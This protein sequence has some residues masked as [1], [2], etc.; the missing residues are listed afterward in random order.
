MT[1]RPADCTCDEPLTEQSFMCPTCEQRWIDGNLEQY[2][3]KIP[4]GK[5]WD[6]FARQQG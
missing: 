5:A 1:T 2:A 6:D 4:T 3:D